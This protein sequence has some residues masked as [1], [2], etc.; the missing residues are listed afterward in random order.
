MTVEIV[1]GQVGTDNSWNTG[2]ESGFIAYMRGSIGDNPASAEILILAETKLQ[3]D[4]Y[5]R[6]ENLLQG[7]GKLGE[8]LPDYSE[9]TTIT[10]E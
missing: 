10:N 9:S 1:R 3:T 5:E 2:Q 7:E 8:D 4:S 6:S